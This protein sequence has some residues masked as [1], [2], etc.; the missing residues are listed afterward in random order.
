MADKLLE[1]Y[2][3]TAPSSS[4]QN[5]TKKH[6]RQISEIWGSLVGKIE[7]MSSKIL[8][9][10]T[11]GTMVP[12]VFFKDSADQDDHRKLRAVEWKEARIGIARDKDRSERFYGA[13]M[14]SPESAGNRLYDCANQ[15]GLS[16]ETRVHGVGDGAS[17]IANQ[18]ERVFGT[19]SS[20]LI[21]FFHL[22]EYL[23]AASELCSKTPKVWRREQQELM[24]FNRREEVLANLDLHL[25]AIWNGKTEHPVVACRRYIA[26]R[27]DQFDYRG[28][29]E[30]DLPIG[31]GEIES[32]HRTV[33]QK[34]IKIPG[35]WWLPETVAHMMDLR[36]TRLNRGWDAYWETQWAGIAA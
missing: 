30:S 31:S 1:H 35:A 27:E 12:I 21:D 33:V 19:Q 15:A 4:I 18:F 8:I 11:D 34:R 9:A 28:A 23:A 32:S 13:T 29:I 20:Y 22:T 3:V 26:N 14:G 7:S 17:W 2:G 6:A 10:E 16:P 36:C 24:K 25:T 5:I